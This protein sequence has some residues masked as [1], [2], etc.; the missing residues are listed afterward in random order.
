MP[1]AQVNRRSRRIRGRAQSLA[2]MRV[3]VPWLPDTSGMRQGVQR[4]N[5]LN[6]Q[7]SSGQI[8]AESFARATACATQRA[9]HMG[10]RDADL[11]P[12]KSFRIIDSRDFTGA[13]SEHEHRS[14]DMFENPG[15]FMS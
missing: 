12:T 9:G 13:S 15:D 8:T 6:R 7:R 14:V 2:Q 11:F 1:T 3:G 4:E 5:R 10:H